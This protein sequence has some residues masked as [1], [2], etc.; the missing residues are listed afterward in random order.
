VGF[1]IGGERIGGIAEWR[2]VLVAQDVVGTVTEAVYSPRLGMNIAVG[3]L[4]VAI[5]DDER[6]LEVDLG[7]GRRPASVC[8]LPFR[9]RPGVGA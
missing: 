8:K 5:A 7:S 9:A 6:R 2:D 1:S 3:M 4:S